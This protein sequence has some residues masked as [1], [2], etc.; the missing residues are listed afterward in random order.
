[1]ASLLACSLVGGPA[2]AAGD[3]DTFACL[4]QFTGSLTRISGDQGYSP[5]EHITF[6]P[7]ARF[8]ARGASWKAFWDTSNGYE[9]VRNCHPV[10]L[11]DDWRGCFKQ[12]PGRFDLWDEEGNPRDPAPP[13]CWAGGLI[14]GTQSQTLAW[15]DVKMSQGMAITLN[16]EHGIIDGVRI[17]NSQDSVVP[18]V[19]RKF[20][21]RNSW[22]SNTRDDAVE[23]DGFASGIIENNLII[24][25]FVFVSMR[26]TTPP[27]PPRA[28][29][30]TGVLEIEH[31]IISLGT[32]DTSGNMVDG[33][34]QFFKTSDRRAPDITL[35]NNLFYAPRGLSRTQIDPS[36]AQV[37][38]CSNNVVVHEGPRPAV[39][40]SDCFRFTTDTS[41]YARARQNWID[42]HPDVMRLPSDPPSSP[43][44]CDSDF[45]GG[46]GTAG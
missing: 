38:R 19:S 43:G 41:I 44:D 28:K 25:S 6:A 33:G 3:D 18:L 21:L 42:C 30:G 36:P 27:N 31:N 20:E 40:R 26:N 7:Q 15:R 22:I 32:R 45:W 39:P 1:M 12:N 16:S 37:V 2:A 35:E 23:N 8:D 14:E 29:G 13:V 4:A 24:D 9:E 11:G 46:K 10:E 17:H 5:V 34:G